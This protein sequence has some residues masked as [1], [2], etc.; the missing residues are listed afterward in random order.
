MTID[1]T[2]C[3][4]TWRQICVLSSRTCSGVRPPETLSSQ[5]N[6]VG[7][8]RSPS[9]TTSG[10]TRATTRALSSDCTPA[11]C[12]A[13]AA[14]DGK[15]SSKPAWITPDFPVTFASAALIGVAIG[16]SGP[17]GLGRMLDSTWLSESPLPSVLPPGQPSGRDR[18]LGTCGICPGP[19]MLRAAAAELAG[20]AAAAGSSAGC[21]RF[22]A[23]ARPEA[24]RARAQHVHAMLLR[25]WKWRPGW[26]IT[27]SVWDILKQPGTPRLRPRGF[28]RGR[29][30]I[31]TPTSGSQERPDRRQQPVWVVTHPL[32]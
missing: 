19:T 6:A 7:V 3:L 11:G 28:R 13:V 26:S 29:G 14:P 27:V 25:V 18:A 5:A 12:P 9:S 15:V 23:D 30:T 16:S 1:S 31:G 4:I 32:V 20:D 22:W 21:D 24:S 10:P 8:S 2:C 17:P